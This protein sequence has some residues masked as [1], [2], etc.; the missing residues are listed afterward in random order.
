VITRDDCCESTGMKRNEER[1]PYGSSGGH[2]KK[3]VEDRAGVDY[4][5][6]RI[7]FEDCMVEVGG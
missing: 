6:R 4:E 1:C 5:L 2:S 3:I 7:F